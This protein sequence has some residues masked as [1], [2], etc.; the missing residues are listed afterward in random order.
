MKNNLKISL[1]IIFFTIFFSANARAQTGGGSL[2]GR[3][4]DPNGAALSGATVTVYGREQTALRLSTVTEENG[5]YRFERLAQGTYLIEAEAAGFA[6]SEAREARIEEGESVALN[7][8]LEIA[9]VRSEIV[10]TASSTAQTIDETSKAITSVERRETDERDEFS[11]A[12]ALSTVPGLRVQQLGGPGTLTSIKTRG[13]RNQDTAILIDGLRFRDATTITG[14]ASSF[15]GDLTV[16]NLSRIEVLRGSGSSLYGTNAIG[17][18]INVITDEGG[19]GTRGQLLVEGGGL[20]F[21]RARA[22]VAGGTSGNRFAYSAGLSHVNVQRGVDRDDRARSTGGQGRVM[23]RLTPAAIFSAR[24]YANNAFVQLNENPQA[25]GNLPASGII[26]AVPLS[27]AELQRYEEGTPVANLNAGAANFIPSANDPDNRQATRFFNGALQFSQQLTER[28]GYTVSY[29]GLLTRRI[30]REGAG[31]IGFEPTDNERNEFDGAINT[32]NARTD[33]QL[34]RANFVTVG[35]EFERESFT[36]RGF[37]ADPAQNSTTDVAQSSHT[38]FAQDQLRLLDGRL[39]FSA[40]FRAQTFRLAAP[41]FFPVETAPYRNLTFTDAANAYTGDG[42]VAYFFR[43][44]ETKLRA[45]VGNGYRAPSLYER[46]GTFFG[47][48]FFTGRNEFT[49]LGDPRL[50]PERSIAFDAGIDQ[51]FSN[52]RVRASLTFFYTRLQETIGFDFSGV[53]VSGATDPFGRFFGY[54]NNRGGLARGIEA[55]VEIAPTRRLDIFTAYTFTNSDQ[56]TPQIAGVV[57]TLGVPHHQFSIVSTARITPRLFVNLDFLATSRYLAPV[58]DP[59]S[60][61][62]RAFRFRGQ[63]KMDVTASYALPLAEDY[64]LRFFGKI[65]NLLDREY[66]ENGFRTPGRTARAGAAFNF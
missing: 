3:V 37:P 16:T 5:A 66:F 57:E 35:Y 41:S 39:Q 12:E 49:P 28:F 48:N 65:D 45:H 1:V 43:L 32:I 47:Q 29:Q 15:L 22:Q 4:T 19:G 33:F 25:I 55:S 61:T 30:I 20:G 17:G 62:S 31:G 26:N 23:F 27:L 56:R 58:F 34:G 63:A 38:F 59:G 13:L 53:F 24:V 64:S 7:I 44:T 42:S 54:F 51:N 60:F 46:F 21:L 8:E 36:N 14:D 9:A 2:T 11:I 52:N 50:G 40:A 18:V 6:R 10:V